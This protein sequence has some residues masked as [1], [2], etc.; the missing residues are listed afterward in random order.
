MNVQCD[1][2]LRIAMF[3]STFPSLSQTFVIDQIRGLLE[4]GH[5]VDIFSLTGAAAE[6]TVRH[7]DFD[8]LGLEQR[9]YHAAAIPRGK[10]RRLLLS[11]LLFVYQFL[12]NPAWIGRWLLSSLRGRPASLRLI[13]GIVPRL[14]AVKYDIVHCQ[15]GTLGNKVLALEETGMRFHRLA[16]T[17]RGYDISSEYL[18]RGPRHYDRLLKRADL[19][20]ANCHFFAKRLLA[21]GCDVEKLKI[22][23][24][25]IACDRFVYRQPVVPKERPL[26]LITVGRL[27][28]KKGIPY[29]LEAVA[30][31]VARGIDVEYRIIGE[32]PEKTNCLQ[33]VEA[34]GLQNVVQ[35][36]GA[37]PQREIIHH[38]SE[39]DVFIASN[40]T[41]PRGD[42]DA[43]INTLK[44]AMATGLPV[45]AT[46]HGGIPELVE[47]G[48]SGFLV[49]ERDPPALQERIE[50]LLSNPAAWADLA[51]AGRRQVEQQYN[52]ETWN[53]LLVQRYLETLDPSLVRSEF[54]EQTESHDRSCAA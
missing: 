28:G 23:R 22:H 24:S 4:R 9:T 35:W 54:D 6:S 45:I 27:V 19:V 32:G 30:G 47:D 38:L 1:K 44:E 2:K 49:P 25:G 41:S 46:A 50:W 17:F 39:S 3:V 37:L 11:I 10:V 13:S 21:T 12:K 8:Q 15:F 18:R 29:A 42:Q 53:D 43:P 48:V 52:L 7:A 16:V 51:K 5:D 34:H 31:L 36:L 26:R 33:I 14:S 40:V 20:M